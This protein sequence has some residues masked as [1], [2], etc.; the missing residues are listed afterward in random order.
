[1]LLLLLLLLLQG[2]GYSKGPLVLLSG[3]GI[4]RH[5]MCEED[6]GVKLRTM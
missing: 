3:G 6:E 2:C 4:G 1:M 5:G